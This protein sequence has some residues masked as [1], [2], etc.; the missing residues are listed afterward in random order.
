[1]NNK[2]MITKS[3]LKTATTLTSKKDKIK[4]ILRKFDSPHVET[5]VGLVNINGAQ[6]SEVQECDE[7]RFL[8]R[9]LANVEKELKEHAISLL[10]REIEKINLELSGIISG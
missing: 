9:S 5:T 7:A 8:H 2:S 10:A 6:K 1:M 3:Q 4:E